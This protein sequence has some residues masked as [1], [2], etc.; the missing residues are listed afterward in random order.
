M[1]DILGTLIKQMGTDN[2]LQQMMQLCTMIT[3]EEAPSIKHP[4]KLP[5]GPNI[6]LSIEVPPQKR[7][8]IS[9]L[10]LEREDEDTWVA[11][12]YG[13]LEKNYENKDEHPKLVRAHEIKDH[14]PAK[15]VKE[16]AK[17]V[18]LYRGE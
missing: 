10:T 11:V 6:F 15:I 18:K 5:Y 12:L 7:K 17:K 1:E 2:R 8:Y 16:F 3:E 14:R 4:D 9:Y 13:M